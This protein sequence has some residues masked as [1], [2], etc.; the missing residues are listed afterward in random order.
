MYDRGDKPID[1]IDLGSGSEKKVEL[2]FTFTRATEEEEYS[3][4]A[5]EDKVELT[6]KTPLMSDVARPLSKNARKKMKRYFVTDIR[7]S[8]PETRKFCVVRC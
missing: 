7:E 6:L 2:Y 3:G 4:V 5:A 1:G 8:R